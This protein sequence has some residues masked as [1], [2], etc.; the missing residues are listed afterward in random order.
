MPEILTE[1]PEGKIDRREFLEKTGEAVGGAMMGPGM[2]E[3]LAGSNQSDDTAPEMNERKQKRQEMRNAMK[4]REE[5]QEDRLK[6]IRDRKVV[7]VVADTKSVHY[8]I[9]CIDEGDDLHL[10]LPEEFGEEVPDNFDVIS[11]PGSGV[12]YAHLDKDIKSLGL[13][14][15]GVTGHRECGACGGDDE[16]AEYVA[17]KLAG[18][19]ELNVPYLGMVYH[20]Y[21]P[22]F[23]VS[24]GAHTRYTQKI[25][26][27]RLAEDA[28]RYFDISQFAI[29]DRKAR[30][31]NMALALKI[32]FHQK[33][34]FS[35]LFV[36]EN[37]PFELCAYY[38]PK[39]LY[40]TKELIEQEVNDAI[41]ET[42]IE[43]ELKEELLK[44]NLIQKH[45]IPITAE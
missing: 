4:A 44:R 30:I 37:T 26:N 12:T 11:V 28:P 41:R 3:I 2:A 43:P 39:D 32:A 9:C 8:C 14:V 34:G 17:K 15:K 29:K 23:H 10:S 13:H 42:E 18:P 7:L 1:S 40:F 31:E 21:R 19:D 27:I 6:W 24:L 38:D 25:R 22:E 5:F 16:K 36:E 45:L 33:M 35:H 20:L